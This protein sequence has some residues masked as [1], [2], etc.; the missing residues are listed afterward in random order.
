MFIAAPPRFYV[1]KYAT[2]GDQEFQKQLAETNMPAQVTNIWT[3]FLLLLLFLLHPPVA[4][5]T[6]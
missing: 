3:P 2:D 6:T 4:V 1:S 5:E